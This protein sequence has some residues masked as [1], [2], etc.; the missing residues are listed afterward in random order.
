[1]RA[2]PEHADDRRK[3]AEHHG[4][5]QDGARF[6][7]KN[8]DVERLLDGA[9][10]IFAVDVLMREGLNRL[11]GVEGFARAC[12]RIGN[13]IL[14][15]AAQRAHP[16]SE[17]DQRH[18]QQQHRATDEDRQLHADDEHEGKTAHERHDIAHGNGDG[19]AD[20]GL[21]ERRVGGQPR[22]DLARAR[23]LEEGRRET[24]H[25][26]EYRFADVGD[27]A[28]AEPRHV[29]ETQ[30]RGTCPGGDGYEKRQKI[31]V[32]AR[33]GRRDEAVVDDVAGQE[34]QNQCRRR[35]KDQ[36]S[37]RSG[38]PPAIGIEKRQNTAQR[39]E[40]PAFGPPLGDVLDLGGE[41][42]ARLRHAPA[43]S[44][45]HPVYR[46]RQIPCQAN[47]WRTAKISG[48]KRWSRGKR[49]RRKRGHPRKTELWT[50]RG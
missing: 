18:H 32:E 6:G 4:C 49:R 48:N 43:S 12:T 26:I 14:A 5:G 40:R 27:H 47:L 17:D 16:P 13:A 37:H 28:L 30:G 46:H 20:H 2:H 33:D 25:V 21:N 42:L 29:I 11:H 38:D 15:S 41:F 24:D 45:S 36:R 22:E 31:Q 35:R 8:R 50:R 44:K 34:C 23:H 1:M 19:R 39:P 3:G 7:A 9:A 10:E